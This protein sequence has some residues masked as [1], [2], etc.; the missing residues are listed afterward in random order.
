MINRARAPAM[1]N[2]YFETR[3]AALAAPRGRQRIVECTLANLLDPTG[4]RIKCL[5]D[6]NPDKQGKFIGVS[7]HAVV[8]PSQAAKMEIGT[9]VV[10]N[11]NYLD[12]VRV[13]ARAAGIAA[14]IATS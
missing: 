9:I 6:V 1:S 14:Q 3:E 7:G 5:I 8:S 2:W 12:E 4:Q 10:M 11:S 13:T